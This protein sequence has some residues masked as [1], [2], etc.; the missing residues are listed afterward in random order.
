VAATKTKPIGDYDDRQFTTIINS[1]STAAPIGLLLKMA[2][3][4]HTYNR[5]L[6]GRQ[7]RRALWRLCF[8]SSVVSWL[9]GHWS[10]VG[11]Q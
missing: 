8:N 5:L 2:E 6:V 7:R 11:P 9:V 3:F 1:A 4:C 10:L